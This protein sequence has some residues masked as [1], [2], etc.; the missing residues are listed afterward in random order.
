MPAIQIDA[1]SAREFLNIAYE[2]TD[3]V[4][5]FLK[6]YDTG[7]VAQR[8]GPVSWAASRRCQLW[9]LAMNARRF[10]VYVSVN[11]VASGRRART[12]DAIA[13]I[14]HLF[15]EVDHDGDGVLSAVCARPDVPAPSYVLHSSPGKLHLFW[16]A[17]A[18]APGYIERLQKQLA[19]ELATDIAATPI[20]QTTRLPGFVNQKHP[21]PYL[22]RIEYRDTK[23]RFS[24]DDFPPLRPAPS[25]DV[26]R[27]HAAAEATA[28]P[29]VER[30]RRYL[31]RVP[32]AVT[33]QHGDLQTF[34]VCCRLTRG[35][36]LDEE[37]ALRVLSEWNER[38]QP[39]WT[40]T[41]LVDKLR[42]AARYGREPIGGLV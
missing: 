21:E 40:T 14:R 11:A 30:A 17:T 23:R 1:E 32:P 25:R 37:Q 41:E 15:L 13:S 4:A 7:Q 2:P 31:T 20:T 10:N 6:S 42:R 35:F 39:P 38:C 36:A 16:R 27:P 33:G 9:L 24:P 34:R 12:R 3:W 29:V 22:V 18:F 8:V 5:L 28:T 26:V 19:I